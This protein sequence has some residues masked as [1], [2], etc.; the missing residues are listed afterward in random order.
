MALTDRQIRFVIVITFLALIT[1]W[2]IPR[3][4]PTPA[5]VTAEQYMLGIIGISIGLIE[6]VV[7][8]LIRQGKL[9]LSPAWGRSAAGFFWSGIG[10]A[11]MGLGQLWHWLVPDGSPWTPKWVGLGI[12]VAAQI[13]ALARVKVAEK[14]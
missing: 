1:V 10:M 4:P 7:S 5:D 9:N 11:G 6:L 12:F 2:L 14:S 8:A 3:T 13:I